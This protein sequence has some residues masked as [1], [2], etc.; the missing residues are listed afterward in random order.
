MNIADWSDEQLE[1]F[2]DSAAIVA[3]DCVWSNALLHDQTCRMAAGFKALGVMPGDRVVLCLPNCPELVVAFTAVLRSGAVAVPLL[4]G[5][6]PAE[7]ERAIQHCLPTAIICGP[8]RAA[9]SIAAARVRCR[10]VADGHHPAPEGWRDLAELSAYPPLERSVR[11]D[12]DDLALIIYTSG[13]SGVSKAVA[14]THGNVSARRGHATMDSTS[15]IV[16]V[17]RPLSIAAAG[18]LIGRLAHR[19]T[20]VLL[21][22]VE[23]RAIVAAIERHSVTT[24]P[25]VPS[26]AESLLAIDTV[27]R[28]AL[29][30]VRQV[31]ITGSPV[32]VS[33]RQRLAPLFPV[34]PTVIYGM[35][36]AGGRIADTAPSTRFDSVGRLAPDVELRIVDEQGR[37]VPTGAAGEIVVKTP[38]MSIG[39]YRPGKDVGVPVRDGWLHTGDLGRLDADSELVLVGRR[40]S[41]IIQ[42]GVN[43]YPEEVAAVIGRRPDVAAC[44]VV[45]VSHPVLGEEVVA[46]VTPQPGAVISEDEII[47]DCRAQLDPR[48]A[49][50]RVQFFADLPRTAAGKIDVSDVRRQLAE[51]G[52]AVDP[53][54]LRTLTAATPARRVALLA[55]LVRATVSRLGGFNG[56]DGRAHVPAGEPTFAESGLDSLQVVR[57]GIALSRTLGCQLSPTLALSYP[58]ASALARHLADVL[59]PP[60]PSTAP[61]ASALPH[62]GA[63]ERIAIIGCACRFPGTANTPDSFWSLLREGVDATGV[64]SRWDIEGWYDATGAAPG[65]SYTRRAALLDSPDLFDAAFFGLTAREARALDPRHRLILEVAWEAIEN[66]GYDPLAT[67]WDRAGVFLGMSASRSEGAESAPSM[68]IGHLCH[69]LDMRGPAALI[70][71]ACSSSLYTVHAA[72][73]S[74]RR[75]ECDIAIAGGAHVIGSA[76]SFVRLSGMGL[77]APD[78]RSK[79][80]DAR[81]DGYGRG[82]G[83]G[84]VVLKRL[85]DA[86]R[87]RDRIA[88]VIRGS[89]ARQ[90]GRRSSLTAPNGRAQQETI[91]AALADAGM[92]PDDVDY[93]EAHGTGTPVGDPIELDAAM[94]VFGTRPQPLIVGSVKTNIGHLEAAAGIAG[95]LKVTLALQ[96]AEIPAQLHFTR[97]NPLLQHLAGS[98]VIPSMP[99]PWPVMPNRRRSAGVTSLGMSGTNVHVVLEEASPLVPEEGDENELA[100]GGEPAGAE[101]HELLCVSAA[102]TT[103][104]Q[105][106]CGRYAEHFRQLAP[107]HFADHCFTAAAGRSHFCRRVAVVASS[108]SAM[109]VQLEAAIVAPLNDGSRSGQ[110]QPRI[111]FLFTGYGAHYIGMGAGLYATEPTFRRA[112]H[113]CAD[114]LDTELSRSLLELVTKGP[115]DTEAFTTDLALGHVALFALQWSLVRLWRSW[116]VEPEV[117]IGHSAGEYAAAAVAGLFTLDDGLRF[118][119]ARGRLLQTLHPSGEM[120]SVRAASDR[121]RSAIEHAKADVSI[122]AVNG[123]LSTVISGTKDAIAAVVEVLTAQG[124]EHRR[125]HLPFASHS[126][127]MDPILGDLERVAAG[128]QYAESLRVPMVS[129]LTG[130]PATVNELKEPSY[131]R[132]HLREPV[133]FAA[134]LQSMAARNCDAFVEIGPHPVLVG[135]GPD[136]I[137]DATTHR[138]WLPSLKRG[139][140]DREQMLKSL[141]DLY[142]LGITPCWPGFYGYAER[143]RVALPTYPFE[144]QRVS[145]G[146]D[147]SAPRDE[148]EPAASPTREQRRA[149]IANHLKARVAE[150]LGRAPESLS[151]EQSILQLGIDS[152]RIIDLIADVRR[153]FGVPCAP[154]D[155]V[156]RPTLGEFVVFLQERLETTEG[157]T[158]HTTTADANEPLPRVEA[159]RLRSPMVAL[160]G[161]GHRTPVVCLHPSGGHITCYLR[162]RTLLGDEWPLIGFQSRALAQPKTEHSTLESMAVDYA[163]LLQ[164]AR[165]VGPYILFGWSMGGL[166][167][168]ALAAELERRGAMVAM[169]GMVDTVPAASQRTRRRRLPVLARALLAL[170]H[171]VAQ[172]RAAESGLANDIRE[173]VGLAASSGELLAGCEERSLIPKGSMSV[174][175]L[176][177]ALQLYVHHFRLARRYRPPVIDAPIWQWWAEEPV[178]PPAWASRTRWG[179]RERVLGGTHF[180]VIRPPYIESIVDDIRAFDVERSGAPLATVSLAPLSAS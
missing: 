70:D 96:H 83:C 131:W 16:L 162:L 127:L 155:F 115:A 40:T 147:D 38:R 47:A 130:G 133:Q 124:L 100:R 56:G 61:L 123:P 110:I 39:Y 95:L 8:A 136:C 64:I 25:L 166:I 78:G 172:P 160:N 73:Q 132:R 57:L 148:C 179:L 12:A 54:M 30:S 89:A 137:D 150:M 76:D 109:S 31:T 17:A 180:T 171:D 176:A 88:A 7:I 68:A 146:T 53:D 134:A 97:L 14:F 135:L 29:T 167:A 34:V 18:V 98:F 5:T 79:A 45:G 126:P 49:P 75:R 74:L 90:D 20:L 19:W 163:T 151:P 142:V 175:T 42:S 1:R 119:T 51:D 105:N 10:I 55:A 122:G 77:M 80:F 128:L 161:S 102:T 117:V 21:H 85:A 71:T 28:N 153:T 174:A 164:A 4:S 91:R 173:L 65:K 58:T 178:P 48:K 116:G 24:V 107:L 72:V 111:G 33:L 114:R 143:R 170:V 120:I 165:P 41:V 152:L 141:G 139:R 108:P 156:A 26:L 140:D 22:T 15:A 23:A 159:P 138:E 118:V 82:E 103:A 94:S 113:E 93:L 13:T 129:A 112:L 69:F 11:R 81:A 145:L 63:Q 62:T 104:L 2:G 168:H 92:S 87:A 177:S 44:A 3:G 106:Q 158:S 66:A 169:V 6:P 125:L 149:A 84:V 154:G 60:A 35:T 144:R 32:S 9:Q 50:V 27:D 101:R 46:C 99:M 157:P 43:V 52:S 36:E 67:T 86:Q 37:D 59:F 121:V